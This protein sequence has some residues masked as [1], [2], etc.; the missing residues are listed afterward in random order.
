MK[1]TSLLRKN[2]GKIAVC[3]IGFLLLLFAA[4]VFQKV[5]VRAAAKVNVSAANKETGIRFSWKKVKGAS[6]YYLRI[7]DMKTK[8]IYS[9]RTKSATYTYAPAVNGRVYRYAASAY[10]S[11]KA[12]IGT[13]SSVKKI[14]YL[15]P[16][17]VV[18]IG[19]N[20]KG[21]LTLTWKQNRKGTGYQIWKSTDGGKTYGKAAYKTIGSSKTL[22]FTDA[23]V[24]IGKQY[25]Y[26]VYVVNREYRSAPASSKLLTFRHTQDAG[27]ALLKPTCTTGGITVYRCRFCKKEL[28]TAYPEKRGHAYGKWIEVRPATETKKGLEIRT[29]TRAGCGA[30]ETRETAVNTNRKAASKRTKAGSVKLSSVKNGRRGIVVR[31]KETKKADGY[32]LFR[33]KGKGNFQT[34]AVLHGTKKTKYTDKSAAGGTACAYRVTAFRNIGGKRVLG[35]V[36][37]EKATVRILPVKFKSGTSKAADSVTV[38]WTKQKKI[39]GYQIRVKAEGKELKTGTVKKSSKSITIKRLN[40]GSYKIYIR[41]FINKGKKTW[42]GSWCAKPVCFAYPGIVSL[43]L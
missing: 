1:N 29:C 19:E 20:S 33:K 37:N 30:A 28:R 25:R 2:K 12:E 40:R 17:A 27:S 18:S 38:T 21:S 8:A 22:S 32:I 42:F 41:A 23:A 39:S 6:Y 15:S 10:N 5:P 7:T 34:L 26:R 31:W 3:C 43:A 13:S 4:I 36:S 9:F 16:T 11:R 35:T 24:A 14:R